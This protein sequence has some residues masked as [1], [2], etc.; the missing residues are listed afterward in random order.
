M[1]SNI[2]VFVILPELILLITG[3][4]VLLIDLYLTDGQRGIN[5]KVTM[6]GLIATLGAIGLVS[7]AQSSLVFSE[8]LVRDSLGDLLKGFTVFIVLLTFIY[9]RDYLR[10]RGFGTGEYHALVLFAT[11]GMMIM[12]S[13]NSFLS[14]YL[15]LE[16]LALSLYALVAFN[17]DADAGAEAAMKYFILGALGSGF[18]LYGISILYGISGGFGFSQVWELL[19]DRGAEH[20]VIVFALVFLVAGVAF[21]FGAVPF[22]M[23]LPD[24][25]QGAPT[26]VT[27][28]VSSA[29]KLAAFAMA[30]RILIEALGV[31]NSIW[32]EILLVFAVLSLIL[33]NVVAIA[34]SNIKRMLAY[35]T[36]SHVGFIFLGLLVGTQSGY[37]AAL[38]Y[39][40]VYALM[41]VGAFGVLALMA[42]NGIEI[43]HL[44]DL[45]G[46][47]ERDAW[48]AAMMSLFMFSMAG[49][50]P[51]V[52][53][54][55]KLLVLNAVVSAGLIWTAVLAVV[56][57][58]VGAF[59]YLRVIKF[60]YFDQPQTLAPLAIAGDA[61]AAISL[62]GMAILLLGIF[63]A[64]LLAWCEAVF[65][66]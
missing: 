65:A 36:I 28:F 33:G 21:K 20:K 5:H 42:N 64:S 66:G 30:V 3:C 4:S 57:S 26:P 47:S 12:I 34:Q 35:S 10:S 29:P 2:S 55:A 45:K 39:T 40:I 19:A 62:N 58:I 25:Y 31:L 63:P 17:R 50:P 23:W 51:A 18:L 38:F 14:L 53:F 43:E 60:I 56:F 8:S 54:M 22:H 11:L 46:L 32:G 13:A 6:L 44:D 59:Y 16:L 52:G 48:L 1:L 7:T 49:V 61:R 37:A 15:G 27:L 9:S 41:A 24:V